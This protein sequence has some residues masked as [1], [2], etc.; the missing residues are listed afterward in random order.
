MVATNMH[1]SQ[2]ETYVVIAIL[3]DIVEILHNASQ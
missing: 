2:Q 1:I 3:A